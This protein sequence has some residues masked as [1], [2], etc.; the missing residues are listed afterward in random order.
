MGHCFQCGICRCFD[1]SVFVVNGELQ[2]EIEWDAVRGRV[3][4][5]HA[6][7]CGRRSDGEVPVRREAA[8]LFVIDQPRCEAN[9]TLGGWRAPQNLSSSS[10]QSW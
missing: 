7:G 1:V 10:A 9:A 8:Q 5:I 6:D 4:Q 3:G 2:Q